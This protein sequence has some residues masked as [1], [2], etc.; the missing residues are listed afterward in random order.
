MAQFFVQR[1]IFAWVIAIVTMLSGLWA[2]TSL[3]VS[4]YPDIAPTTVRV[5]ATYPG[6][7]ATAVE[8]SVTRAIEDRL[9]GLEGL[10]YMVSSSR[11]GSA[12]LQLTFDNSISPV[13]AE[14]NVQTRVRQAETGL[15]AAVQRQGV[16][17]RRSTSSILLVGALVANE[18]GFSTAALG[19]ILE[20]SVEND[21]LRTEGVGD[22]NIFGSGYAMRIWL[23]PISLARYQLTPTDVVNAVSTQNTNVAVGSLGGQPTAE[24]QQFTATITAQSQLKTVADFEQILLKT[25]TD[26]GTVRLNDVARL[27]IGRESYGSSSRYS[28]KP[29]AGFGVSLAAG[30]NAVETAERVKQTLARLAPGLPEGAEFKI[31]YDTSPFVERSINQVYQTLIEAV[32]LVVV[33]LVV[34]LHSWRATLIPLIAVPVVLLGTFT[35]LAIAGY[36][37][38]TLTMFA[39]VLAIGLL[40]DDAIVVVENVE[41]LMEEHGLGPLEATRRSMREIVGA[42]I[43]IAVVLSAVFLPMAF[44]GGS[45]GVIYRQFSITIV[46]AMI[47]SLA[48]ALIL[49]PAL[50]AS[51]LKARVG[52]GPLAVRLFNRG[53]SRMTDVYGSGVAWLV[54]RPLVAVALLAVTLGSAFLIFDRLNSSFLPTEDQGML[55]T[56]V[57]LPEGGTTQ[58]TL[59]VIERI[60]AHYAAEKDVASTFAAVGFSFGGSGQ[61]R[62]MVFVRLRDFDQREDDASAAAA[63]AGRANAAFS[64]IRAGRVFVV[65]PPSI[66]RLG[67]ISGF[68]MYL[69]DLSGAGVDALKEA[70]TALAASAAGDPRVAAVR[71]EN[72]D[73]KSALR[74]VIDQQ[75]AESLG[76]SLSD[77]NNM[78][79]TIFAGTEVNDFEWNTSLRPVIVQA[80]AAYRMQPEDIDGWYARNSSGE[81]VPFSVFTTTEW[82]PVAPN[83]TRI[84]GTVAIEMQGSAGPGASSGEAMEAMEELVAALPGGYGV[85]WTGL[86][87]EE[88]KS[89]ENVLLLYAL[90]ALIVFLALSA[91]Y[92]SWSIPFA[93]MLV[94]PVGILGALS[95]A[96]LFGQLN[97]VYFKVGIL[98]TI[99]LAARNAILIVEFA[100][101]LVEEGRDLVD[102]AITA[103]RQ[104]LRPIMMTALTFVFGVLPLATATGAGA[105]AQNAIGIGVI[106][107]MLASTVI[108]IFIVPALYVAVRRV[109]GR[110]SRGVSTPA[111]GGQS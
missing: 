60:E 7:T 86:S 8:N 102:A 41:R 27:E 92:E 97:D 48:V 25:E 56:M 93:V 17:V 90:S 52:E 55:M 101:S 11:E 42:L 73:E 53:F 64:T 54:R 47:L 83:L 36:S 71:P 111:T 62:A 10:L 1:P 88:R 85:A 34:F 13:E 6:A 87:Y 106:G 35:V 39:M 94:V 74:L 68:S 105:N 50:C 21:V 79:S 70:A 40:V 43:G 109:T 22:V 16:N 18:E 58:Q 28:G 84:D 77:I 19:N 99:G 63:I 110:F 61:N 30:A 23:D 2:L 89:G 82:R 37:I 65:Q 29:A 76:L 14:N 75:K 44:F 20:E 80:D 38:N 46:T 72:T 91:L 103:S 15:P 26:G 69:T 107:G 108:G 31:A 104:R 45:T 78:L 5:S 95:A 51:L 66:P 3:P 67:N 96:W 100:E 57:T 24:G 49:T 12:S 9:T 59:A 4:Q 33:V 81:M 32:I 98:T